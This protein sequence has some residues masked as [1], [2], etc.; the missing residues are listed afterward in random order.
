MI[1]PCRTDIYLGAY[2]LGALEP[3]EAR[4]VG[5]HVAGC[6]ACRGELASL[7]DTVM[8]LDLLTPEDVVELCPPDPVTVAAPRRHRRHR[9]RAALAL[10][11]AALVAAT[12]LGIVRGLDD[13]HAPSPTVAQAVDPVT[14]ARAAVTMT[15]K[16]WGTELHLVLTGAYP[17][18][19]CSLIAHSRDGRTTT[20]AS[21]EADPQGRAVVDGTT[22]ISA[23]R[24]TRLDVVTAGGVRLVQINLTHK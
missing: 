22:A 6:D 12:G 1:R 21:W 14:H 8:L 20:A 9:R 2:V 7:A 15:S 13:G 18:G 23:D 24:L 11:S 19:W 16:N 17:S 5:A 3:S 10:A 4:A